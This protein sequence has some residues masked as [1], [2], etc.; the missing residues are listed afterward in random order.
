MGVRSNI[1]TN[2]TARDQYIQGALLLKQEFLGPTT[3]NFGIA[4]PSVPVS[5]WDLFVIWHHVAMMTFTPATQSDR[6]AAHRGPVFLPW[7]RWMMLLLEFQ[8][9]RVLG[10]ANFGLPYWDWAGGGE[11]GIF[12]ADCMGGSGSPISSGAFRPTVP[13]PFLVKVVANSAGTLVQANRGLR[14]QLNS[15][16]SL[17]TRAQTEAVLGL[18]TYDASPWSTVSSGMRNRLEGWQPFDPNSNLHNR[19]H[20]WVS[21]DMGPSTSPN[22]PVFYL[23]HCNVDRIWEAWMAANGRNYQPP[24]TAATSLRRHRLNDQMFALI[25]SSATLAQ[26]LNVTGF[27]TYDS[28]AV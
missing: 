4:G 7:H 21:G 25:S 22:D 27:Y 8:F 23:N 2:T 20:V 12:A 9:Q 15:A 13:T 26:V 16:P 24:A 28:L 3:Q 10:D 14:R 19:V 1:L 11:A 17:P 6:N 5:T 18:T